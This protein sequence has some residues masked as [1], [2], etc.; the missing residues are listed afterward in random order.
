VN[1][2]IIQN[3]YPLNDVETYIKLKELGIN[4]EHKEFACKFLQYNPKI[5]AAC[6][7]PVASKDICFWIFARIHHST[8]DIDI[9][10]QQY[11][12]K[13]VIIVSDNIIEYFQQKKV[14]NIDKLLLA[15]RTRFTECIIKNEKPIIALWQIDE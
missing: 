6:R 5:T 7:F 11:F 1:K 3:K 9:D 14:R 4:V 13:Y 2:L 8:D 12:E 15:S 10:L